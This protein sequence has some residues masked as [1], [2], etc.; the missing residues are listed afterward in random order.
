MTF[1]VPVAFVSRELTLKKSRFI[2]WAAPAKS[3][4]EALQWLDKAR[5]DYPDARHHC[6]AY[7]LGTSEVA[8]HAAANDDG[9]P[10]GTAGKPILNVIQHKS[11]GNVVVIVSRYFGG[12]KLGAGGLVRAYAGAT[13]EVLSAMPL[14]Q[15]VPSIQVNVICDFADEQVI[16]HFCQRHEGEVTQVDYAQEVTLQLTLPEHVSAELQALC[17]SLGALLKPD[18]G[19]TN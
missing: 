19:A 17:A 7:L 8:T 4:E 9:E 6:W 13:E 11:I 15:L 5:T 10:S 2:A 3:R 1:K 14:Q 16:R 12:I 18:S